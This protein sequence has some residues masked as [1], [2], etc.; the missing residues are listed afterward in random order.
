MKKLFTTSLLIS[1]L[2]TSCEQPSVSIGPSISE[3]P[4]SE[5]SLENISN[6]I[7]DI[8]PLTINLK[9]GELYVFHYRIHYHCSKQLLCLLQL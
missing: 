2:L 5:S 3:I 6:G 9:V 1:C 8:I 7:E 4:Q